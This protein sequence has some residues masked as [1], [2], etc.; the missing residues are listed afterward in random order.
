VAVTLREP[1]GAGGRLPD[2]TATTDAQGRYEIRGARKASS[3]GLSVKRDAAAGLLGRTVEAADT[4]AYEPVTA[5]IAVARGVVLTGRLTDGATGK[6]VRG[7]ACAGVLFDNPF[8]KDRPELATPDCYGDWA[9][10]D[11]GGVYRTV[12]PPGPVLLMAGPVPTET[13]DA[14]TVYLRYRRMRPDPDYPQYFDRRFD[15]F[16]SPGGSTTLMQGQYCKVLKLNPDQ[17]EVTADIAFER[18]AAFPVKVRGPD[19]KPAADLLAA[20]VSAS[21]AM[22]AT[23]CAGDTC[24]V[25]ELD[26]ARPRRVVLYDTRRHLAASL[27][28]TGKEQEPLVVT[29]GPAGKIKGR[30][31]DPAG[32]PIARAMVHLDFRDRAADHVHEAVHG[33]R[34]DVGR[35]VETNA[36]GEFALDRVLP[37]LKFLVYAR[38]GNKDLEPPDW[39]AGG[40]EARGGETVDLGTIRLKPER[41]E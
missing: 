5:D 30:L 40:F 32:Q 19:G 29:L 7:F 26:P 22:Y 16:R 2:L 28:L 9:Y 17:R 31:V 15:G 3:Y 35:A 21:E 20:G 27:T 37:G 34:R 11:Q 14:D 1:G 38:K 25:Y 4:P 10:T 36:A 23:R 18:A 6:P 13:D 8:V 39:K 24:A 12:V 33:S 41:G